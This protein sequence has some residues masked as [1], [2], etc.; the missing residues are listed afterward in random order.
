[1]VKLTI[2][3]DLTIFPIYVV[4]SW[5]DYHPDRWKWKSKVEF[6]WLEEEIWATNVGKFVVKKQKEMWKNEKIGRKWEKSLEKREEKVF[7]SENS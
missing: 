1:M 7:E 5:V 2:P 4:S 6:M 3:E